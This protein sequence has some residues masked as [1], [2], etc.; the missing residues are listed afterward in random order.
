MTNP[1]AYLGR[2]EAQLTPRQACAL[3]AAL[4]CRERRI[5]D[6]RETAPTWQTGPRAGQR[7]GIGLLS[8]LRECL[9]LRQAVAENEAGIKALASLLPEALPVAT[10]DQFDT[11]GHQTFTARAFREGDSQTFQRL[12]TAR[13]RVEHERQRLAQRETALNL[14]EQKFRWDTCERFLKWYED[15]RAQEVAESNGDNT[16]K[17]EALGRI[18]FGENWRGPVPPAPETT[19]FTD[20]T[21][22]EPANER[23][24]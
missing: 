22:S 24:P 9:Q 17:I 16:A 5:E 1:S 13:N 8:R 10:R 23:I 18:M 2:Y 3:Q 20:C 7:P 19:D 14:A 21:D 4:L 15:R 11:V 12:S 6:I